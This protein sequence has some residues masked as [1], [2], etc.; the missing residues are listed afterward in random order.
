VPI[1]IVLLRHNFCRA[2]LP[3]ADWA[4][5]G[6]RDSVIASPTIRRLRMV[7]IESATCR[8]G[9]NGGASGSVTLGNGKFLADT[10]GART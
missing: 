8:S 6:Q 1:C 9:R 4:Q 3:A 5:Q 7:W 10:L 2:D